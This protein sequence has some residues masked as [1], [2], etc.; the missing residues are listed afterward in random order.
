MN[1]T[2][3]TSSPYLLRRLSAA[4]ADAY[5]D[6]RLEGLQ[7]HPEAFGGSW[8]EEAIMPLDWFSDRL[9]RNIVIA[10]FADDL[11]LLGTAGLGIQQAPKQSH[12]GMLWGMYVR[13]EARGT[14]LAAEL[15]QRM[16]GEAQGVVEEIQLRV[17]TS[18]EAAV[19]I[20]SRFGFKE[21]T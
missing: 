14:G 11:P 6:L 1:Q 7:N 8:E 18:N 16:I 12:K 13:P 19:R 10:G 20:Y 5:R 4:D 15:V 2:S 3:S 9:E 21:R 17:V